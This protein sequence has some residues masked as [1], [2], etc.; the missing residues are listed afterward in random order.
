MRK[1]LYL[2][3]ICVLAASLTGPAQA[4]GKGNGADNGRGNGGAGAGGNAGGGGNGNAG[5]GD[6][7]N[8]GGG[9]G[10]NGPS[11][12][13]GDRANGL[14]TNNLGQ[15][16]SFYARQGVVGL[17]AGGWGNS[18]GDPDNGTAHGT[19]NG[20]RSAKVQSYLRR[21]FNVGSTRF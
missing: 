16:I 9:K 18:D 3:V 15:A 21:N 20:H 19:G 13:S 17:H 14:G 4:A 5:G 7:S 10:H 8:A 12:N 2:F 1:L 6:N 11:A